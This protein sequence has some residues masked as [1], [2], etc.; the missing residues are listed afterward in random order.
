MSYA[1]WNTVLMTTHKDRHQSQWWVAWGSQALGGTAANR[2][3]LLLLW[4][5]GPYLLWDRAL[6]LQATWDSRAHNQVMS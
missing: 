2:N 1:C 5:A 3:S 6:K 4:P